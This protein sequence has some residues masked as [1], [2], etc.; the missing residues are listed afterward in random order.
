MSM[1]VHVVTVLG[2]LGGN[3]SVANLH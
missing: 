2:P 3:E 1:T